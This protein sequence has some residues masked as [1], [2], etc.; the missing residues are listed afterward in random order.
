ML[1]QQDIETKGKMASREG[2]DLEANHVPLVRGEVQ[3]YREKLPC[4]RE[5][6]ACVHRSN[7]VIGVTVVHYER[8]LG[9]ELRER[10]KPATAL[11]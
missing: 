7:E 2:R 10:A 4:T 8:K 11:Q 9:H 6:F 3:N 1:G 5:R